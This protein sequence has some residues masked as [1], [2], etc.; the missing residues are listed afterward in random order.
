MCKC[1]ECA[2]REKE[3]GESQ[4][5]NF[6]VLVALVPILTITLFGNIGLI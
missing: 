4:E 3:E 6:A 1:Q 5:F 2:R